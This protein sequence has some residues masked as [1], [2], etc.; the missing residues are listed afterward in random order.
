MCVSNLC[1]IFRVCTWRCMCVTHCVWYDIYLIQFYVV[2]YLAY[3]PLFTRYAVQNK[4]QKICKMPPKQKRKEK[5]RKATTII[6]WMKV[7]TYVC[8]LILAM[9]TH[10][11]MRHRFFPYFSHDAAVL[12]CI[13]YHRSI[14]TIMHA[15]LLRYNVQQS[16]F[17]VNSMN[18]NDCVGYYSN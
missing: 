2:A 1:R 10:L 5:K 6:M 7:C 4:W 3:I 15:R 12:D 16:P 8:N 11:Q 17:M 9:P 18:G 13:P 14:I